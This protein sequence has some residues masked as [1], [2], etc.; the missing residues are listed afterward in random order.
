M[1]DLMETITLTTYV[2]EATDNGTVILLQSP[3]DEQL[4]TSDRLVSGVRVA[5]D[6][7]S[8]NPVFGALNSEGSTWVLQL[9]RLN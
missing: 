3:K 9:T 4:G 8:Q 2:S 5:I 7:A 6:C 1:P